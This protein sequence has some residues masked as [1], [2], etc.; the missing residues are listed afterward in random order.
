MNKLLDFT[1]LLRSS[2]DGAP[3]KFIQKLKG[4][5][6]GNLLVV[7]GEHADRVLIVDDHGESLYGSDSVYEAVQTT[8]VLGKDGS[9]R[10]FTSDY[11]GLDLAIVSI[12]I[13]YQ[14]RDHRVHM[15][16]LDDN[17]NQFNEKLDWSRPIQTAVTGRPVTFVRKFRRPG[18][19]VPVNLVGLDCGDWDAII[20]VDDYGRPAAEHDGGDLVYA[21]SPVV[22]SVDYGGNWQIGCPGHIG[23]A[24]RQT[25]AVVNLYYHAS[26]QEITHTVKWF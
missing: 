9:W 24:I 6:A 25:R 21:P 17:K 26:T 10:F 14:T 7:S 18:C 13:D 5:A 1:K 12:N 16:W 2:E 4:G 15:R 8:V 11:S 22:L 20:F 23:R 19:D 3:A